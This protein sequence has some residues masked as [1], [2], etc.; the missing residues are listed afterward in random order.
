MEEKGQLTSADKDLGTLDLST[1]Y[2][3]VHGLVKTSDFSMKEVAD[4][5]GKTR[6]MLHLALSSDKYP[7]ILMDV[8]HCLGYDSKIVIETKIKP[9]K[10]EG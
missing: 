2:L 7:K 6:Q 9:P 3:T 4:C 8:L 5:I 10:G 1:A